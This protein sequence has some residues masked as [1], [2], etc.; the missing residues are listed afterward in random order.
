MKICYNYPHA[1]QIAAC[2]PPRDSITPSRQ[3]KEG[4]NNGSKE[5]RKEEKERK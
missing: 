2:T 5:G 1:D 3:V 4:N